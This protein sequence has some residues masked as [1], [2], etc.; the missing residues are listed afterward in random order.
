MRFEGNEGR[1]GVVFD[2]FRLLTLELKDY[3][4]LP[5]V[6]Q[7]LLTRLIM[8]I[9]GGG[10]GDGDERGVGC[11]ILVADDVNAILCSLTGEGF[12]GGVPM[13]TNFDTTCLVSYLRACGFF[14]SSRVQ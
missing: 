14:P 3:R 12:T 11:V 1:C 2:A 8:V 4:L 9:D 6:I 13:G 10:G 5:G 7:V